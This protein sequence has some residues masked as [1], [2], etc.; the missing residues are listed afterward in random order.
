MFFQFSQFSQFEFLNFDRTSSDLQAFPLLELPR[1]SRGYQRWR[2][3]SW[4]K[5]FLA[6]GTALERDTRQYSA[7]RQALLEVVIV[8]AISKMY[9]PRVYTLGK[10]IKK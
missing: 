9:R 4:S 6:T 8:A 5:T 3:L 10:Y 7:M 1:S 2:V